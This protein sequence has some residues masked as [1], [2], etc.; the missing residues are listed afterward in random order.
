MPAYAHLFSTDQERGEDLITYLASLGATTTPERWREVQAVRAPTGHGSAKRGRSLFAVWCSQCHGRDG[1]GDGPL[2]AG[3][4][5][6]E[7]LDLTQG[8]LALVSF[9][10]GIGTREEGLARLV[11]FGAPGTSM[12]GHEHLGDS[13]IADLVAAVEAMNGT[14]GEP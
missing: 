9:G 6:R 4:A 11:R 1:R 2:G 3:L 10:P 5:N 13:E 7:R 14:R 8:P 12:P